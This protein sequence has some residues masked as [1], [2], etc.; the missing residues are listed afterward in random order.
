MSK[1]FKITANFTK[2]GPEPRRV[3]VVILASG[4]EE[5]DAVH[6]TERDLG[7]T[8][9]GFKVEELFDDACCDYCGSRRV[10]G[11]SCYYCGMAVK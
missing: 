8:F 6:K 4:A 7:I 9:T 3:E 2:D 1:N 5:L 10:S 11:S